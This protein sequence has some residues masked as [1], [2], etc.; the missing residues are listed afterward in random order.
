MTFG[1]LPEY[2][3]KGT[4]TTDDGEKITGYIRGTSNEKMNVGADF[5]K[6]LTAKQLSVYDTAGVVRIELENGDIFERLYIVPNEFE[7]RAA[8]LARVR[9]QGKLSLWQTFYHGIPYYIISRPAEPGKNYVLR[10]D[11]IEPSSVVITRHY[12]KSFLRLAT[13]DVPE[14]KMDPDKVGFNDRD[15]IAFVS[16]YNAAVHSENKVPTITQKKAQFLVFGV[17]GMK[18]SSKKE[19]FV[20]L[21]YRIFFPKISRGTSLT[22]GFNYF[23]HQENQP[24]QPVVNQYGVQV[25]QPASVFKATVVSVPV[26]MQQNILNGH[27]RPYVFA[28]LDFNVNKTSDSEENPAPSVYNNL[29]GFQMLYGGGIEWNIY[30]GLMLKGEYRFE[31]VR[32]LTMGGIYYVLPL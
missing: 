8:V 13:K 17:S 25:I 19:Y 27:F 2:Y 18:T 14:F 20:Q 31:A 9:V 1:Q 26:Q 12:Y 10:D 24:S 5:K 11:H 28:G 22:L 30:K 6:T 21:N 23:Q 7:K 4:I 16:A 3:I 32:H 15:M 29:I